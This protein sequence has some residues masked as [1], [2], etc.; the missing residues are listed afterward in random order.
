TAVC[1]SFISPGKGSRTVTGSSLRFSGGPAW[2]KIIAEGISFSSL[3]LPH[4]ITLANLNAVMPQ[5]RIGR[6]HMK[7]KLRQAIAEKIRLCIESALFRRP[8]AGND[9]AAF[10]TVY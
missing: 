5:N 3:V 6:R 10:L 9:L 7:E 2:C 8:R 4:V 1:L